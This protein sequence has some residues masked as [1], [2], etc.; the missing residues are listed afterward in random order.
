MDTD[1]AVAAARDDLARARHE[2]EDLVRIPSISADPVH[3]DDVDAC[4]D[5]V[6][7]PHA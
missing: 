7:A 3:D 2:L 4:G 1:T 5:A 6:A